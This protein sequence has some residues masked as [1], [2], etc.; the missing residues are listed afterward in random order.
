MARPATGQV[1]KRKT[2]DGS[3]T[4]AI[5]FHVDRH[6]HYVTLGSPT[7]GWTEQMAQRELAA[8]LRDVERG[9]WQPP[10]AAPPASSDPDPSFHAFA[11]D[12]FAAK[13]GEIQPNTAASYRNDLVNHLLPFFKDHRLSEITV[14]EVDKYRQAKV[15]QAAELREIPA[16]ERP[17]L[18]VLDR[19]GR[20]HR[21][22]ERPLS[23]RSINMHLSLL[24]QILEVAVDRELIAR[25]PAA[26]RRRRLKASRP[27]PV[28]LDSAEH[29][30]ALLEAAG[31]IDRGSDARTSGRRPAM[32]T[33]LFAGLR[34]EEVTALRWRD[35][36]LS[37]GRIM[38]R[39]A[40][41][42][43]GVREVDLL[44]LLREILTEHK[45]AVCGRRERVPPDELVFTTRT[46][47]ARDRHN[48]RQRVVA[49]AVERA[50]QLLAEV[51]LQPLPAGISPHKLR[52]TFASVLLAIG[53]DIRDVMAQLG[54]TDPAFTLRVYTHMM[55]RGDSE[56]EQLQELVEGRL[57]W[58][59]YRQRKPLRPKTHRRQT[60][61]ETTETPAGAE[62]S[63]NRGARI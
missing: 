63:E 31:A 43:A 53:C 6:R 4:F 23:P 28:H 12:W 61:P 8:V 38:V 34:A 13:R 21:R 37:N 5:R 47:S 59:A 45:M 30:A 26:G 2:K 32:A 51:D 16:D 36:D 50:D 46:G 41:T 62:V 20:R 3:F 7:D 40:K 11:S 54:H 55:R 10:S 19:R 57:D 14:A 18:E 39:A 27:R 60:F 35:V 58:A 52:H 22:R 25:N 1:V 29:L 56:R 15:A 24:A 44:P 49:P 33:L 9:S 42:D 48:L 17:L